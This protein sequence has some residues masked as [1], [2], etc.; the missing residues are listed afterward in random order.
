MIKVSTSFASSRYTDAE[1]SVK[2]SEVTTSMTGNPYFSSPEPALDIIQGDA[3]AFNIALDNSK[4]GS[5]EAVALKNV[6]RSKLE[7]SLHKLALWLNFK[8]E[9]DYVKLVTTGFELT[10]NSEPVGPLD[11]PDWLKVKPGKQSGYI[12]L[13]CSIVKNARHYVFSYRLTSDESNNGWI[14]TDSSSRK[15]LLTG[16]SSGE[17]YTFRAAG[18]GSD[19]SRNWGSEIT[20]YVL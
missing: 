20:S 13:E 9:G 3:N 5:H 1:L 7:T 19:P 2:A 17:Q 14:N 11:V 18:A 4:N 8:A 15:L 12:E 16:L 6:A 10:R